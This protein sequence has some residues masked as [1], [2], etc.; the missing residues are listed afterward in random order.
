MA[1]NNVGNIIPNNVRND[2]VSTLQFEVEKL[3]Y[4]KLKAGEDNQSAQSGGTMYLD[5]TRMHNTLIINGRK[6][7]D[8]DN[9]QEEK[10]SLI[11]K[12]MEE[13]DESLNLLYELD[14]GNKC[15]NY[16]PYLKKV[17]KKIFQY[18]GAKVPNE[19]IIQELITN[20]NQ[21]GYEATLCTPGLFLALQEFGLTA[22]G[23]DRTIH[24]DC[25]D[26][27]SVALKIDMKT[28][29][30]E[31]YEGGKVGKKIGSLPASLE[32]KLKSQENKVEYIDGKLSL[33]LPKELE[34]DKDLLA[35]I[36]EWFKELFGIEVKGPV[37]E[38]SFNNAG[39]DKPK[40]E[41]KEV[42]IEAHQAHQVDGA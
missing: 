10:E 26:P 22:M 29:L 24:I 15:E 36:I 4:S 39:V 35:K 7:I 3:D 12:T 21:A 9:D 34:Q 25:H 27:N 30:Y 20:C 41:I 6:M 2:L 14:Y 40:T 17:F 37:I 42:A 11:D 8:D 13:V 33:T 28:P 23:F 19:S 1:E 16:H 38:H 18:A 31:Q 32:F 5:L